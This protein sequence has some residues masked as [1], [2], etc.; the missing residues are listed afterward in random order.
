MF[1]SRV[2]AACIM[3][4]IFCNIPTAATTQKTARHVLLKVPDFRWALVRLGNGLM[5]AD[6]SWT[7]T[8]ARV[9]TNTYKYTGVTNKISRAFGTREQRPIQC[10]K[11]SKQLAIFCGPR[12]YQPVMEKNLIALACYQPN[13]RFS[14]PERR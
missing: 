7:F 14:G 5:A 4:E 2:K 3:Q 13:R 8:G 12:P 11:P 6:Q 9:S 10:L 1:H